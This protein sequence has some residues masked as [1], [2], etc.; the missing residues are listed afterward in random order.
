M[1]RRPP[2]STRTD[3]LFPYTT[4]FRS[5]DARLLEGAQQA[6]AGD[7][8]HLEGGDLAALERDRAAV[9]RVVA[10][11]GV[12][13]GGLAGA[14]GADESGDLALRHREGDGAVGLHAAERL[15]HLVDR[16]HGGAHCAASRSPVG[17]SLVFAA[18][19]PRSTT[20]PKRSG[21]RRCTQPMMPSWKN[22]TLTTMSRP[23]AT[24][25][26]PSR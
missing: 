25:C 12:E 22:T 1:I 24:H 26:Q 2:R 7:L 19:E 9:A 6:E 3:T 17:R 15:R 8:R 21:Q 16:D 20:M 23:R 10:D 14:V 5:I 13:Q 11:D 18:A 4:L